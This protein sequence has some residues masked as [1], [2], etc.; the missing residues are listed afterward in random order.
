MF[1]L[2]NDFK[3][4]GMLLNVVYGPKKLTK[5][6]DKGFPAQPFHVDY[7][8]Q[9]QDCVKKLIKALVVD[10]LPRVLVEIDLNKVILSAFTC[11]YTF[12]FLTEKERK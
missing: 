12:R 4:I 3:M 9:M 6:Y 8:D 7:H 11:S 5:I 2:V 1:L 10:H